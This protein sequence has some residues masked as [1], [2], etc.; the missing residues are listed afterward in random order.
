MPF[1]PSV[2]VVI[3]TYNQ[4]EYLRQAIESVL[5]QTYDDWE[6]VIVNDGSTDHTDEVVKTYIRHPKVRYYKKPNEGQASAKKMGRREARGEY[7]AYLDSAAYRARS[8]V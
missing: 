5:L 2:S 1:R 6:L 8:T 3:A 4:A 7:V